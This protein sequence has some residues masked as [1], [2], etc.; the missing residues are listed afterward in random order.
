[1][2]KLQA[3]SACLSNRLA[4]HAAL[5]RVEVEGVMGKKRRLDEEGALMREVVGHALGGVRA[6]LLR[7]MLG[8]VGP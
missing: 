6:E 2:K 3:A 7:E 5:P 4:R 1:M 8:W